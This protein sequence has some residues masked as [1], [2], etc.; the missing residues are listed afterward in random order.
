MLKTII[1]TFYVDAP[2]PRPLVS[3]ILV[4]WALSG[5]LREHIR[6]VGGHDRCD[7]DLRRP[8]SLRILAV[9]L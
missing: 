5:R 9:D 8:K 1:E 2:D 6:I 7:Q 3:V 4:G